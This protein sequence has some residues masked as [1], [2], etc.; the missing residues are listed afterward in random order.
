M[1]SVCILSRG[2]VWSV[3][4][5]FHSLSLS[6]HQATRQRALTSWS[7]ARLLLYLWG[8]KWC[9]LYVYFSRDTHTVWY[10]HPLLGLGFVCQ[11]SKGGQ[12]SWGE[13]RWSSIFFFKCYFLFSLLLGSAG[14]DGPS[15]SFLRSDPLL[16]AWA[17]GLLASPQGSGID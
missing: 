8:L 9:S 11:G 14:A 3:S 13:K 17:T 5:F 2:A 1:K 12:R 4:A 16:A 6:V 10:S 7:V 15:H